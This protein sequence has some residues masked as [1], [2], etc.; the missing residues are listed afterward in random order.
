MK[1]VNMD[2]LDFVAIDEQTITKV[3]LENL[4]RQN[5][6]WKL[7]QFTYLGILIITKVNN[8]QPMDLFQN[9]IMRCI[10]CIVIQLHLKYWPCTFNAKRVSLHIINLRHNNH[11][12][13]CW[14]WPLY[15]IQMFLRRC[16]KHIAPRSPLY[17]ESSKK[18]TRVYPTTIYISNKFKRDDVTQMGFIEYLMLFV[19]KGLLFVR[20]IE[21]IWL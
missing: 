1:N 20:T 17:H 19:V 13:T 14:I 15:L 7:H 12:K 18:R 8:N 10:I 21:S 2:I 16:N 6:A 5:M 4:W 9:Q 3:H 11:G